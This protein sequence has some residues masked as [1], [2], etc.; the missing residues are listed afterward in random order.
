MIITLPFAAFGQGLTLL[1]YDT[2]D[3]PSQVAGE[4]YGESGLVKMSES[5]NVAS[6][7]GLTGA[8][9]YPSGLLNPR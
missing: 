5:D 6:I 1:L 2:F 3:D 7:E 9:G 8:I 4:F